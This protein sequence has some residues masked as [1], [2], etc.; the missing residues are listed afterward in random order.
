[1]KITSYVNIYFIIIF[2]VLLF[3][4]LTRLLCRNFFCSNIIVILCIMIYCIKLVEEIILYLYNVHRL[5]LVLLSISLHI[6]TSKCKHWL[7]SWCTYTHF[8]DTIC[9]IFFFIIFFSA[10]SSLSLPLS[11]CIIIIIFI[12]TFFHSLSSQHVFLLKI[13]LSHI[14]LLFLLLCILNEYDPLLREFP[15]ITISSSRANFNFHSV[16]FSQLRGTILYLFIQFFFSSFFL[17]YCVIFF[18]IIAFF[19]SFSSSFLIIP[20][21]MNWDNL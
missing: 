16:H 1:M 2:C 20:Y 19:F 17:P 12:Y 11:L 7:L 3:S 6:S 21:P 10:Y 9:F 14:L 13:H 5:L 15:T 18:I 8:D 4:H